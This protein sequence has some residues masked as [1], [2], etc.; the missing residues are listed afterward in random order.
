MSC[1]TESEWDDESR[2]LAIASDLLRR[3]TG[4]LGQYLPESTA[5]GADP[6]DYKSGYRYVSEGP[7]IDWAEKTERDALEALRKDRGENANLNGVYFTVRRLDYE[8]PNQT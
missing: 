5:P 4:A 8:V 2:D 3:R 6:T 7:F 1:W